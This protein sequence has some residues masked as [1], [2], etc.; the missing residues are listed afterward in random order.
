ML[1]SEKMILHHPAD[2]MVNR[3]VQFL[4]KCRVPAGHVDQDI[5]QGFHI[6]AGFTSE[7]D[8]RHP[9]SPGCDH[10]VDHIPGISGCAKCDQDIPIL[11][12]AGHLLGINQVGT[13]I[14]GNC[15]Y[16]RTVGA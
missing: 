4:D 7:S 5:A 2:C 13:G 8:N 12:V 10:C 15:A 9:D 11:P 1:M 16:Q 6:P 3:H 14:I